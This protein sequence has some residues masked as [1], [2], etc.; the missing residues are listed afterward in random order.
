MDP[1]PTTPNPEPTTQG[2]DSTPQQPQKSNKTLLLIAAGVI[3]L[4]TGML[5][6]I[7]TQ[8]KKTAPN[9][10]PTTVVVP[11]QVPVL[12]QTPEEQEIESIDVGAPEPTDFVEVEKDIQSL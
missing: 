10:A 4:V 5:F 2:H 8:N 12:T 1:L 6:F 11:T 3:V 9:S 7:T